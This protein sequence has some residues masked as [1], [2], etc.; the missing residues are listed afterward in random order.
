MDLN[1]FGHTQVLFK[2]K[3][4]QRLLKGM[5]LASEAVG[6]T[7]G[8]KGK[9]VLI[10][11]EGNA[12]VATKDGVTVS[13]SIRLTEP[14]ER[15]GAELI[16]EAA[17]QTND[18]AGDGTTTATIL[19][20]TM[21]TEGL[22]LLTA[23]YS[24]LALCKGIEAGTAAVIQ[25]LRAEAVPVK[26][27]EE[28][29]QV[30]TVSANGDKGIG[31][32]IAEA[33]DQV[34]RDGIVTVEDAK[35]MQ[36]T[37]TIVEGMQFDRG[38]LSPFF[39]TDNDRMAAIH[40]G[41]RV[42]IT[43]RKIT[44]LRQI[45]G[46]LEAVVQAGQRLLI[47]A[48]EV[49]G[50][51]LNALVLNRVK[52]NLPIVAIKAPGYGNHRHDLLLDICKLT[53]ANL[54]SSKM[55]SNLEEATLDDLGSCKRV[56]VTARNTTLIGDGLTKE[57]LDTHI[58]ELKTQLEDVT[59][60]VETVARLKERVARLAGGVAIIKVGGATE[61]EMVER[62]YR[63]EDALH[64]TRAAADEGIVPGGGT[65]LFQASLVLSD[66]DLDDGERAGL[67]IVAKACLAPLCRIVSNAGKSPDVVLE[68]LRR[69][70]LKSDMC[71]RGYD[72]AND[73]ELDMVAAGIIDPVKVTR[74]ALQN[75]ASVAVTFL[76]LDAVIYNVEAN[77]NDAG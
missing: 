24:S 25:A 58:A 47:I 54:I 70:L 28:I 31:R 27:S 68:S 53:G 18:A 14:I 49:E 48:D 65:A 20:H 61:V 60:G 35:G 36:T 13:K 43:D 73:C 41:C 38:Y 33:M 6:C 26:T 55:G 37:M 56:N 62:K 57:E 21:V 7:L 52:N 34:G 23:G 74:T 30:G 71:H 16:R 8:P 72:A 19:T 12:P 77:K 69:G 3:A 9:T 44:T 63:I 40:D 66:L 5:T 76:T 15:M 22:K 39:V 51:A 75:A 59:I 46:I 45:V 17:S 42:L 11:Q 32:L 10:Q 64:A 29:A 67:E 4:R 50:E 2:D 1:H